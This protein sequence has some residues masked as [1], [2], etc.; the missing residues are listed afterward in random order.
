[1]VNGEK[2]KMSIRVWWQ[3]ISSS[4]LTGRTSSGH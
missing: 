4:W 3:G 2:W 1:L